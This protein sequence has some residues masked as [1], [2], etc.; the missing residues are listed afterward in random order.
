[1]VVAE[2]RS[3]FTKVVLL[4]V[5]VL[6]LG[7]GR[8]ATALELRW[9]LH[10]EQPVRLYSLTRWEQ[11]SGNPRLQP[12]VR[13]GFAVAP[14]DLEPDRGAAGLRRLG[15]ETI[16]DHLA[17]CIVE[18]I[19]GR[20]AALGARWSWT[21]TSYVA[22]DDKRFPVRAKAAFEV[23]KVD[24]PRVEV[25][26][27][28]FLE[29][30]GK[31]IEGSTP[32]VK[33]PFAARLRGVLSFD[34]E[35]GEVVRLEYAERTVLGP[36]GRLTIREAKVSASRPAR[37]TLPVLVERAL[38]RGGMFLF[39]AASSKL[40]Q[41][42]PADVEAYP[43]YAHALA[44]AGVLIDSAL[45]ATYVSDELERTRKPLRGPR[46]LLV[47]PAGPGTFGL[48]FY[49]MA[50]S[51]RALQRT[52][53]TARQASSLPIYVRST[54]DRK[55]R[56]RLRRA[57]D[58]L[59]RWRVRGKGTWAPTSAFLGEN[60]PAL[61]RLRGNALVRAEDPSRAVV[62][63]DYPSTELAVL[64]LL[65]AHAVGVATPG[66]VWEQVQAQFQDPVRFAA[67]GSA[68]HDLEVRWLAPAGERAL[69]I[70][71]GRHA[72]GWGTIRGK[73]PY[74]T[75]TAGGL[76][77]LA[78]ARRGRGAGNLP[79]AVIANGA[80]RAGLAGLSW[81]LRPIS[82]RWAPRSPG[83][84]TRPVEETARRVD[85]RG[86]YQTLFSVEHALDIL[87]IDALGKRAWYREAA[88][89]LLASQE[90][91]G[92]WSIFSL[93]GPRHKADNAAFALLFLARSGLAL[94]PEQAAVVWPRSA[95]P[96]DDPLVY[97][98]PALK[99]RVA[100]RALLE[101]LERERLSEEARA[102]RREA[103]AVALA[104]LPRAEGP[105]L[106]PQLTR[107]LRG[108]DQAVRAL[109]QLALGRIAAPWR[110]TS[111]KLS[112]LYQRWALVAEPPEGTP[113]AAWI[114]V[115]AAALRKRAEHPA[116][117]RKAAKVLGVLARQ[118]PEG[119]AA[120][121]ALLGALSAKDEA[122]RAASLAALRAATN[123]SFE[124][125]AAWRSWWKKARRAW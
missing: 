64:A 72:A 113:G 51:D 115:A 123:R 55:T 119:R 122:V 91:D 87:G 54:L 59:L 81:A 67:R 100:V 34:V 60:R 12:P 56:G 23:T 114:R 14:E 26:F 48:A 41:K 66:A 38:L 84:E 63:A 22:T 74:L 49:A 7:G 86:V 89:W 44:R 101:D 53:V 37:E 29:A 28:L 65:S 79:D 99:G 108:R 15:V 39:K 31:P 82:R 120:V 80:L 68:R 52:P 18:G 8:R 69:A 11:R 27:D 109:A 10:P 36:A 46:G 5:G 110:L 83:S 106:I 33:P 92:G 121:D 105:G 111:G 3:A 77:A 20:E 24:V 57:A 1:V 78:A 21:A 95:P 30:T 9:K 112:R 19:Q 102:A 32:A 50:L 4:M 96:V 90:P 25:R 103:L 116:I 97:E 47:Q 70:R 40:G 93:Q 35:A 88:L 42:P 17:R 107:S 125:P 62:I 58:T 76:S 43:L 16:E 71:A 85:P 45:L 117:R 94:N 75:T 124:D 104:S 6:L 61:E 73:L 13:A 118:R 2:P 98:V